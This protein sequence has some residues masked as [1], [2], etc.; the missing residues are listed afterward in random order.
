MAKAPEN[1]QTVA[2]GEAYEKRQNCIRGIESVR[3]NCGSAIEDTTLTEVTKIPFPKYQ[4]FTDKAGQYRF[5]LFASNGEVIASSEGYSDKS[6]CLNGIASVQRIGKSE[7]EDLT[8]AEK[9]TE[10]V[11]ASKEV[12][13]ETTPIAPQ[14]AEEKTE[15]P[16]ETAEPSVAPEPEPKP[17]PAP[18]P[19]SSYE[20][21]IVS[22]RATS[23]TTIAIALV[24]AV[25]GVIL[26][27]LGAFAN[28]GASLGT[29]DATA[30]AI[31]MLSGE[32]MVGIAV[33]FYAYKY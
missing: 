30:R 26:L 20:E 10:E 1:G 29:S 21:N 33:L 3:R 19:Q 17:E 11:V 4:I 15:T 7:I 14:V 28:L 2:I 16:V 9:T 24:V 32:V 31:L 22:P 13:T 23:K 6:G 12:T 18:M 25:I 27:V 5:N 8:I